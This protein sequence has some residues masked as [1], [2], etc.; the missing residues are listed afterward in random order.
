MM[1]CIHRLE[2]AN[3]LVHLEVQRGT[4]LGVEG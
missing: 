1:S 3:V 2:M 4:I